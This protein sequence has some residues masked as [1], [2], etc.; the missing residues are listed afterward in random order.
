[1]L[2]HIP[3]EPIVQVTHKLRAGN[4]RVAWGGGSKL[5]GGAHGLDIT[6]IRP[7]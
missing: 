4:R 7:E 5:D 2:L 6:R 3:T 1:L